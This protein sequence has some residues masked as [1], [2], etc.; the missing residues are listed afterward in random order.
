[1]DSG[2]T[3]ID[4]FKKTKKNLEQLVHIVNKIKGKSKATFFLTLPPF[5]LFN[6]ILEVIV[7]QQ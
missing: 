3:S 1:M 4:E 2:A 7:L 5:W 6:Q